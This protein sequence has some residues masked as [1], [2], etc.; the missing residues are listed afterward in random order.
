M[1]KTRSL[2]SRACAAGH[3][4]SDGRSIKA[5]ASIRPGER[6]EVLTP[7]G[8]RIVEVVA[9]ADK[10][11]PAEVAKTLFTDH[12]PPPEPKP[13]SPIVRDRGAGRPEKRDRRL[14]RK[15]RGR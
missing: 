15:L 4:K 2:A 5:S 13:P 10:R 1:F 11:G 8:L 12:S 9:L 3:V 7:G 14:L 6:L